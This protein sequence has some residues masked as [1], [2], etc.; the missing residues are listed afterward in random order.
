MIRR[1]EQGDAS[2]LANLMTQLGYPTVADEMSLRMRAIFDD[3]NFATFVAVDNGA[4]IGMIGVSVSASYEHN[5]RNGRIIALAVE[6][7]WRR[8]GIGRILVAVA[9]GYLVRK[10]AG[11]IALTSGFTREDA[12]KFYESLGYKRTGLRFIK[13]L[14][15]R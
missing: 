1:A 4:V 8:K 12:H 10:N 9:E 2:A 3:K 13:E 7:R 15:A 11:R 5:D 6:K 14:S